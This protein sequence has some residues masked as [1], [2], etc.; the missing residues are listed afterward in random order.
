MWKYQAG[1]IANVSLHDHL[2]DD[3]ILQG[4]DILLMFT[5]GFDVRSIHSLNDT[6][7][8]KLT[9]KSQIL[10]T[11]AKY[12]NNVS[13]ILNNNMHKTEIALLKSQFR[14]FEVLDF[15]VEGSRF[16]LHGNLHD[17][18]NTSVSHMELSFFCDKIVCCWDCYKSDSWYVDFPATDTVCRS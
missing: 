16:T 18:T 5:N 13:C 17:E 3:I 2:I 1:D 10:L 4:N 11:N 6:G 8:S 15:N 12:C 9:G 14:G 7:T